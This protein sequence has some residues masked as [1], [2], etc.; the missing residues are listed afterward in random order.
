[1]DCLDARELLAE[2]AVGTLRDDER[3]FELERHL[4]SCAGCRR[5]AEQMA[6]GAAA[7]ALVLPAPEPPPGLEE[8]IAR[9]ITPRRSG[10]RRRSLAVAGIAAALAAMLAAGSF[11]WALS[12]TR[13]SEMVQRLLATAGEEAQLTAS[14]LQEAVSELAD[15]RLLSATLEP[16]RGDSPAGGG[17]VVHDSVR[18]RD[19]AIIVVGGLPGRHAPYRAV[20]VDGV[21]RLSL[22]KLERTGPARYSLERFARTDLRNVDRVEVLDE[23]SKVALAGALDEPA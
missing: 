8:R 15:S 11:A 14:L 1:M 7:L 13:R 6:E 4:G 19:L 20:L 21:V 3:A 12:V 16:S 10:S 9:R 22:G 2:R 17:A 5:E 23:R 18:G